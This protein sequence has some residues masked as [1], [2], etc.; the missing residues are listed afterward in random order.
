MSS[1]LVIFPDE[2]QNFDSVISQSLTNAY[3]IPVLN[4]VSQMGILQKRLGQKNVL[5]EE[6][7][8][9]MF[10]EILHSNYFQFNKVYCVRHDGRR[11]EGE[12]SRFLTGNKQIDSD[13]LF[14]II[15]RHADTNLPGFEA[16]ENWT[17]RNSQANA[18]DF[19]LDSRISNP[20][21]SEQFL[22]LMNYY[23][24]LCNITSQK[25][26]T[27]L[28]SIGLPYVLNEQI[29]TVFLTVNQKNF[30]SLDDIFESVL[31]FNIYWDISKLNEL[32]NYLMHVG[33]LFK[34]LTSP[35]KIIRARKLAVLF[36]EKLIFNEIINGII[37]T[38]T[39]D[40]NVPANTQ[41]IEMLIVIISFFRFTSNHDIYS[42]IY[43]SYQQEKSTFINFL[44]QF[45]GIVIQKLSEGFFIDYQILIVYL[46][47]VSESLPDMRQYIFSTTFLNLVYQ[48]FLQ[49]KDV[50]AALKIVVLLE[51]INFSNFRED[52]Q[53]LRL[54]QN[55][56][57]MF[58]TDY[59][60]LGKAFFIRLF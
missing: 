11:I 36:F 42:L 50:Q 31:K 33:C 56:L 30:P 15:C 26:G 23:L 9:N 28:S 49:K 53:F 18:I 38:I 37:K 40:M 16:L 57:V 20:P 13:L 7:F 51:S 35:Q 27:N 52:Q 54:V 39:L 32:Y 45:T 10:F 12:G 2:N 48:Y 21:K 24:V 22:G 14:Q 46:I 5:S 43:Q 58:V 41:L 19:V 44:F 59:G 47:A 34:H 1:E 3:D 60:E 29:D 25:M 6:E 55:I 17:L 4:H 8:L